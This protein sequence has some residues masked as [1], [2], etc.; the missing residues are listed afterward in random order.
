M[1]DRCDHFIS[2]DKRQDL[3]AARSTES[4]SA[5][6]STSSVVAPNNGCAP[7]IYGGQGHYFLPQTSRNCPPRRGLAASSRRPKLL[8]WPCSAQSRDGWRQGVCWRS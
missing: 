1:R 5:A 6:S 2:T 3:W 8:T 4:F 7:S